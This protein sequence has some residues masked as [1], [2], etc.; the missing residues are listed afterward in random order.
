LS[1]RAADEAAIAT[2]GAVHM[3][4]PEGTYWQQI[5]K[6]TRAFIPSSPNP[7]RTA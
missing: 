5:A 4:Q 1:K 6:G 3:A 7:V 2:D